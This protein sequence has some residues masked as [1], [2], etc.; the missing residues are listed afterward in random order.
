[1]KNKD[2]VTKIQKIFEEEEG[3]E[4]LV[5]DTFLLLQIQ[6]N[7]EGIA[8]KKLKIK[9]EEFLEKVIEEFRERDLEEEAKVEFYCTDC[10]QFFPKDKES[11]VKNQC[12]D[13]FDTEEKEE[14]YF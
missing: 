1:M 10:Y 4:D 14:D 2:R 6:K 7:I 5:I 8:D 13:C 12:K 9:L 3:V 11:G